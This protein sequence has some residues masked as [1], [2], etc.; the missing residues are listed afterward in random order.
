MN[1][2]HL[3]LII[4]LLF[5]MAGVGC[6]VHGP[7]S[8]K[9][10][11]QQEEEI[12]EIATRNLKTFS[13]S[14][15]EEINN[16]LKSEKETILFQ[17][18]E[19]SLFQKAIKDAITKEDYYIAIKLVSKRFRWIKGRCTCDLVVY[20]T[21]G[22]QE[23][24]EY[25]AIIDT[26]SAEGESASA[27][28]VSFPK[29]KIKKAFIALNAIIEKYRENCICPP[30]CQGSINENELDYNVTLPALRED[31]K[32]CKI[33]RSVS[34]EI[35]SR[36]YHNIIKCE[37][38]RGKHLEMTL[39]VGNDGKVESYS[40]TENNYLAEDVCI[41]NAIQSEKWPPY[42]GEKMIFHLE[43]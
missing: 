11:Y 16:Q 7:S 26:V 12:R 33:E 21:M 20:D 30:G 10:N 40:F 9:T 2:R 25:L 35:M 42:Y 34:V 27:D 22:D 32:K 1:K 41:E 15:D 13:T 4:V 19:K 31:N 5:G 43:L 24:N 29:V 8:P 6:S 36:I 37:S 14:S 28:Q 23:L 3:F 18:E 38:V 39:T 17:S